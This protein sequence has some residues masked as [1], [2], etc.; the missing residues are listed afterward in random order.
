LLFCCGEGGNQFFARIR[1]EI[2]IR[3][4]RSS[5][6]IFFL[7][8]LIY[9]IFGPLLNFHHHHRLFVRKGSVNLKSLNGAVVLVTGAA[10]F[11]GFF[12][13][14]PIKTNKQTNKQK[15][16]DFTLRFDYKNLGPRPLGLIM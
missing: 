6:F 11:I 13:L 14:L 4:F 15:K 7:V 1:H 12:F 9:Y 5:I 2:R 3:P 16:Q 10:G 8:V